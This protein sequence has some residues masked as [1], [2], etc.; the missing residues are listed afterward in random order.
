MIIEGTGPHQSSPR[1]SF[2]S[3]AVTHRL[4]SLCLKNS[5]CP[6]PTIKELTK[7]SPTEI[8][9][10][11]WML[12]LH[13]HRPFQPENDP[14][15]EYAQ[16]PTLNML[17]NTVQNSPA[18]TERQCLRS[19]SE[20]HSMIESYRGRQRLTS[21]VFQGALLFRLR[22]MRIATL[23]TASFRVWQGASEDIVC[24]RFKLKI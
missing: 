17:T 21:T 10:S 24:G 1:G 18:R 14:R 12:M 4:D 16:P 11:A 6:L 15:T 5:F 19:L 8:F 3:G 22:R 23:L 13:R 2:R 20:V 7:W 9:L